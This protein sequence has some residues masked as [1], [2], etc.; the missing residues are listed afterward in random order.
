MLHAETYFGLSHQKRIEYVFANIPALGKDFDPDSVLEEL[1]RELRGDPELTAEP[2]EAFITTLSAAKAAAEQS[3]EF[4]GW[5]PQAV[6][7]FALGFAADTAKATKTKA[8]ILEKTAQG[9]AYLR[10]QEEGQTDLVALEAELDASRKALETLRTT[11]ATALAAFEQARAHNRRRDALSAEIAL[12]ASAVA[13][14][15]AAVIRVDTLKAAFDKM[16]IVAQAELDALRL[17][18]R[19]AGTAITRTRGELDQVLAAIR[20]NEQEQRD[21]GA[22]TKCAYCGATGDGWKVLKAAEIDSALAGL[23]TKEAQLREHL[24]KLVPHG[25]KLLARLKKASDDAGLRLGKERDLRSEQAT[26]PRN[27]LAVLIQQRRDGEADIEDLAALDL[28]LRFQRRDFL[29]VF[30]PLDQCVHFRP[31]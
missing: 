29:A 31:L 22:K 12:S 21:L 8:V 3:D 4:F 26:V 15:K 13:Q 24:G 25:Q 28:A 11:K 9:L 19:E 1:A 20:T 14:R 23:R 30:Q 2:V 6:I 7:D 17:E 10:T 16:P 27:D 5:T 18:E